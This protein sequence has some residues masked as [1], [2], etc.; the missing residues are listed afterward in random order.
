MERSVRL[1]I[2]A[3]LSDFDAWVRQQA[4]SAADDIEQFL[5]WKFDHP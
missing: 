3:A 1:V 2:V 5:K 4:A